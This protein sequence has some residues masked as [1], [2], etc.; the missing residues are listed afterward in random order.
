PE[1][2][3][4]LLLDVR[5]AASHFEAGEHLSIAALAR[6][7]AQNEGVAADE[8]TLRALAA[9]EEVLGLPDG[10]SARAILSD[11]LAGPAPTADAPSTATTARDVEAIA[12][13]LAGP[14]RA[15]RNRVLQRLAQPDFVHMAPELPTPKQRAQVLAWCRTLAAE[16]FPAMAYPRAFGG[17]H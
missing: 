4:A 3:E 10:E 2:L 1:V 9:V 15:L 8:Q 7:I 16:G 14:T 12:Q 5:R 11:A 17:A 6:A 13:V